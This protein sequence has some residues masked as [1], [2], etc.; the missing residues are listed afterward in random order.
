[1]LGTPGIVWENKTAAEFSP[2]AFVRQAKSHAA[3]GQ[4]HVSVYWPV[5]VGERSAG[6]TLAILPLDELIE[7]LDMTKEY[8]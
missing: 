7:L 3:D 6:A 2:L 1:M 5:G 8:R 4:V